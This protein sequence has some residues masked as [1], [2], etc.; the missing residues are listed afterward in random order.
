MQ[1]CTVQCSA[2][3]CNVM[4]CSVVHCSAVQCITVQC[5]K[6]LCNAVQCCAVQFSAVQCSAV[7]CSALQC[8]TCTTSHSIICHRSRNHRPE[9][10][11]ILDLSQYHAFWQN[12][13]VGWIRRK[14][15][16]V[17]IVTEKIT[18]WRFWF[19][20]R[21]QKASEGF[22]ICIASKKLRNGNQRFLTEEKVLTKK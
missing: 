7:Q 8:R 5:S 4:Q 2:A 20:T 15:S 3:P 10:K 14:T 17:L 9:P 6:V 1:C 19:G 22:I 13:F 16:K 12:K 21:Y 18:R 11:Y